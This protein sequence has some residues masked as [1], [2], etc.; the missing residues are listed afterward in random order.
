MTIS[1]RKT[2]GWIDDI[3]GALFDP[4]IVM[5]GGWG[6]DLPE[7]MR[8]RVTLERLMENMLATKESREIT[9]TDAEAT[10]YLFTASLTAP[11]GSDWTEI[12]VYLTGKEM[13]DKMPE[14]LRVVTLTDYQQRELRQLK[15]WIYERRVKHRKEKARGQRRQSKEE[16]KEK[17]LETV[18]AQPSFF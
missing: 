7:W 4:I 16:S 15:N 8:T 9:A 14:D 12:Y 13:K 11:I 18:P 2:D 5:P 6:D 17:E 1:K 10:C 3:V